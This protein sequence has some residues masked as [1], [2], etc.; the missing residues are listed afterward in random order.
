MPSDSGRKFH[1]GVVC[2]WVPMGEGEPDRHRYLDAFEADLRDDAIDPIEV[3][4]ASTG[5]DP[6]TITVAYRVPLPGEGE[7]L[8]VEAERALRLV[9]TYL[10]MVERV[11][12]EDL[13]W[14]PGSLRAAAVDPDRE[15]ALTWSVPLEAA[16]E[17]IRGERTVVDLI[18]LVADSA[19]LREGE[20]PFAT[21][22]A[23][24][25]ETN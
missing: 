25:T 9:D 8:D 17:F 14:C 19:T 5:E 6:G 1:Y 22:E 11:D 10:A 16:R 21:A 2:H 18:D 7:L 12:A 23:E 15:K 20:T 3:T 13:A 4:T 24:S